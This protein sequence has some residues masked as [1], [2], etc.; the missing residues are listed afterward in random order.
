[1]AHKKKATLAGSQQSKL[2]KPKTSASSIR[3]ANAAANWR[4][5]LLV[6]IHLAD[7][8]NSPVKAEQF[9]LLVA[10][11]NFRLSVNTGEPYGLFYTQQVNPSINPIMLPFDTIRIY[12][13]FPGIDDIDPD[14]GEIKKLRLGAYVGLAEFH[15]NEPDIG[16]QHFN[17]MED[18]RGPLTL[19]QLITVARKAQALTKIITG[20]SY[21]IKQ[22]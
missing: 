4:S 15:I 3:K 20:G 18:Y 2:S 5:D 10:G 11:V 12:M 19:S 9:K 17:L 22:A 8:V 1:M 16:E 13:V 7:A 21:A 14:S 6:E